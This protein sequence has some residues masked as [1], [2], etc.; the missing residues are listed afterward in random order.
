MKLLLTLTAITTFTMLFPACEKQSYADTKMFHD[1]P[2]R[3]GD[4]TGPTKAEDLP[5]APPVAAPHD[6]TPAAH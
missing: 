4:S 5:Q 6:T 3:A 2:P 1:V